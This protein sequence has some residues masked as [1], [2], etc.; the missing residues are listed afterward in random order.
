MSH[1]LD[2][3]IEMMGDGVHSSSSMGYEQGS[4]LGFQRTSKALAKQCVFLTI[5]T[6]DI[7]P[8]PQ[9]SQQLY[10]H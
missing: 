8:H 7:I 5:V 4:N 9:R 3:G 6:I 2:I 10:H 1:L